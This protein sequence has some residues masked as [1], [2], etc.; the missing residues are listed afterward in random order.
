MQRALLAWRL[1]ALVDTVVLAVSELVTNA[2]RYG[3]PP[4]GLVL[5]RDRQEVHLDVHDGSPREPAGPRGTSV[6]AE[7]GRGMDIVQALAEQ[8]DCEQIPDD[9]KIVH[10][11]F[12]VARSD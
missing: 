10:A 8:V 3:R 6:T 7:S 1:P 4:V 9:G 12:G 11:T 2:V 5:Q